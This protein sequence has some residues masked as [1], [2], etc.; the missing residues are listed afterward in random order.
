MATLPAPIIG[1]L[2]ARIKP[3]WPL[4]VATKD[5]GMLK[6]DEEHVENTG[7]LATAQVR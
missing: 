7:N 5:N 6:F 3:S 4:A 1:A 2:E